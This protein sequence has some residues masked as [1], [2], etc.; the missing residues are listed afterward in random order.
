[1]PGIECGTVAVVL[2]TDDDNKSSL[3]SPNVFESVEPHTSLTWLGRGLGM[4]TASALDRSSCSLVN[5]CT[6]HAFIEL[7]L[8]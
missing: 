6:T 7:Q 1:M 4:A 2:R 3:Y 5:I 8:T